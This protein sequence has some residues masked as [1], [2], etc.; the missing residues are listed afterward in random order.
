[1]FVPGPAARSP[2][3]FQQ[4]VVIHDQ[5][6]LQ[7]AAQLYQGILKGDDR[8]FGA[9]YRLGLVRMQQGKFADA[10]HLFR[11]AVKVDKRFADARFQ[12]AAALTGLDRLEEAIRPYEKALSLKPGFPEAHNNLGF[13]LEKLGRYEDAARHYRKA[14]TM[15]PAYAEALTNLGNALQMLGRS[16]EAIV[17]YEKALA[18]RPRDCGIHRSIGNALQSLGRSK[19]AITH[20][21][22]AISLTPDNARAQNN[23]ESERALNTAIAFFQAQQVGDSCYGRMGRSAGCLVAHPGFGERWLKVSWVPTREIDP[24]IWDGELLSNGLRDIGRPQIFEHSDW[25]EQSKSYRAILMGVAREAISKTAWLESSP[26]L[27]AN[28]WKAL[29]GTLAAV[30][31]K[32]T[33]R[34]CVPDELLTHRLR[35]RFGWSLRLPFPFWQTAHGDLHWKNL[36]APEF[37]IL[38]WE[39]WGRAP[40][41][42]DVAYL[43]VFS[44]AQPEILARLK[45]EFAPRMAQPEYDVAFLFAAS[46]AMGMFERFGE[47][48]VIQADLR[49]EVQ[50]VL[51]AGRFSHLCE[52]PTVGQQP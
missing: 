27:E 17:H 10:E 40:Y 35:E 42:Y 36:S 19:E 26:A 30:Q 32:P 8:H 34:I 24:F 1:M 13:V 18:I 38:D 7:E 11:R 31:S 49:S 2:S 15:N 29:S 4:A 14:L 6:R 25:E 52:Y 16:E 47:Y 5:G 3:A 37:S 48:S 22:E 50:A 23:M 46:G 12:L 51:E 43:H 20:Y 9:L 41:G 21:Q 39:T 45:Q 28:W 44:I 33:D